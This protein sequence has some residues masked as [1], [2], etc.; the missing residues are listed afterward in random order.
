MSEQSVAPQQSAEMSLKSSSE[1]DQQPSEAGPSTC[2]QG[3]DEISE[4]EKNDINDVAIIPDYSD[5]APGEKNN[6]GD[7]D[8]P[9]YPQ[10]NQQRMVF[11]ALSRGP[12]GI[13]LPGL[14]PGSL[15]G[16]SLLAEQFFS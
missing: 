2:N 9:H 4:S 1:K 16:C 8:A 13:R 3:N 6:D 11:R 12:A 14:N 5:E 10:I 15:P 7:K